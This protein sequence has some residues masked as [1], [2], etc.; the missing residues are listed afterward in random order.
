MNN[1]PP[2]P[3]INST[4]TDIEANKASL[5]RVIAIYVYSHTTTKLHPGELRKGERHLHP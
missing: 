1:F 2:V 3:D 5:P 4:Y